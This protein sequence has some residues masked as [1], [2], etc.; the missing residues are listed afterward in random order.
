MGKKKKMKYSLSRT[1]K[2]GGTVRGT[3]AVTSVMGLGT[4]LE[5]IPPAFSRAANLGCR[6]KQRPSII[7]SVYRS[8]RN[9][10]FFSAINLS[11]AFLEDLYLRNITSRARNFSG[12]QLM[13]ALSLL[14]TVCI[15]RFFANALYVFQN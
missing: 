14:S 12:R 9:I 1:V 7:H 13:M 6:E 2:G 8:W 10:T 11:L 15:V 3:Q 4:V 5:D